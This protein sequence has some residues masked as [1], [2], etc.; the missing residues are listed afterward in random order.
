MKILLMTWACDMEDVSEPEICSKWVRE[1]AK[2]H[3]VTLFAVSR[4][5]RYGCVKE[6][7]PDLNVIEWKD[8]WVPKGLEKFRS[9]AKPGYIPYYFKARR[10][11]RR[12]FKHQDFDVVHQITPLAWRY[13]SPAAGL[14][15]PF[16]RGPIE[17]G[18]DTPTPLKSAVAGNLPFYYKL[19]DFDKFRKSIDP[20]L[21]QSFLQT[22]MLLLAAPYVEEVIQPLKFQSSVLE[23]DHGLLDKQRHPYN[24]KKL[25]NNPDCVTFVYVGR[26]VRTKGLRDAIHG[27]AAA[28]MRQ[29]AKL[30]VIGDGDDLEICKQQ[31]KDLNIEN[32]VDFKGWQ[33]R[34][35]V[36]HFY[37]SSDVF[38]F[39]SFREPTGGVFLEAM[40]HS[41][42]TI[43]CKYGGPE[44]F[45]DD[46]CGIL[47][48][49]QAPD[50]YA[51]AIGAA[52][53]RLIAD[54]TL[55]ASMSKAAWKRANTHFSWEEKRKRLA[56]LYSQLSDN[57]HKPEVT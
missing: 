37:Q 43:S 51:K 42:A 28:K 41:L 56:H 35:E 18:L 47:I 9:V 36:D 49:P 48:P 24:D 46:E 45:I 1:I 31:A 10:F 15:V 4:P 3:D 39:P 14:G 40:S 38:L 11:L 25:Q 13:P 5:D 57:T 44:Y 34:D 20:I 54:P 19:R 23:S 53:D 29:K 8:I 21:K 7:F 27:L 16:I 22:E 6:Q 32:L 26:I 52:I 17:G 55:R 30:I 2:D 12:L 33:T 50:Q